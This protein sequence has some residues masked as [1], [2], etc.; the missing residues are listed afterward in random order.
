MLKSG[1]KYEKAIAN[2]SK[3]SDLKL[4]VITVRSDNSSYMLTAIINRSD[5]VSPML[6]QYTITENVT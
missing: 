1:Y 3:Y 4:R 2:R 6:K 5:S